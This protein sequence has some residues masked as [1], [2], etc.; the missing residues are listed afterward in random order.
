MWVGGGGV[1]VRAGGGGCLWSESERTRESMCVGEGGNNTRARPPNTHT[2]NTPHLRLFEQRG[3][4]ELELELDRANVADGVGAAAVD[5][6]HERAAARDVAQEL[7]P[8]AVPLV[9]ALEQAG[10]VGKDGR[11]VVDLAHA[12]V[13]H[14]RGKGVV[15]DLGL[16]GG[17]HAEQRALARVWHADDADVG[18]DLWLRFVS[19]VAWACLFGVSV[20]YAAKKERT[21]ESSPARAAH[22]THSTQHSTP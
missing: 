11:A 20:S 1:C 12:E 16:G 4:E 9:R 8:Q 17:Q 5:D 10:H 7:V 3:V 13:W 15:G 19:A 6:V 2:H 21:R 14:E 18:D 22:S